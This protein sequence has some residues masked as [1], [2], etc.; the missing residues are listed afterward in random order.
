MLLSELVRVM[1]ARTA[2]TVRGGTPAEFVRV[3][4]ITEDSRTVVPGSLFIA[5]GG[6][7]TDGRKFVADAITGG[8]VAVM[9]DDPALTIDDPRIPLVVC[10]DIMLATAVG[11]EAF[12]GNPSRALALFGVTGTNG[13]ST[14]TYLAWK[15][16]NAHDRRCGLIG[17]VLIDDG[18]EVARAIMTTP[19]SIE[20]SRTFASMVEC[21]CVAAS[22]EVSSHALDQQ[23]CAAFA[24]RVGAF[25]NLTGDHLDYHK[26]MDNY[27]AAKAR[28]F[29]MLPTE[30]LAV[31]N[32]NDPAAERMV[33]DCKAPV[34]RCRLGAGPVDE[35]NATVEILSRSMRGMGLRLRGPWGDLESHVD[36]IG[37]YNAMNTLQAVAGCFALGLTGAD[38]HAALPSLDAPPGRLQRVSDDDSDV[39]VFVDYAHTDDALANVLQAV[40]RVI[41][42]RTH[43]SAAVK[44]AAGAD[45]SRE[46]I[47]RLWVVFG[48]GGDKDRTKR[49]RMGK[50]AAELADV[51]VVTSD[52]PR[53]ER[54]GQIIDEVLGGIP[55]ALRSKFTVQADRG[56]AIAH[57][58]REAGPRDVVVLA[59]KGHENTQILSDGKGG[60]VTINFDDAEVARRCLAERDGGS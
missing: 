15:L 19:P 48:C 35:H 54:P 36:L 51:V 7:K 13:K 17:T 4:D 3:C 12:Y 16:L 11:A 47:G 53:S 22:M 57:A 45:R 9:T 56:R 24:F 39:T 29:E 30:G 6:L 34:L 58:I 26:T 50:A 59:G 14:T 25:T 42:G 40:G 1:A 33:R 32:A 44:D 49:P 41:P 28:L 21:G 5:R 20:L 46:E 60:L 27:G 55:P 2:A 43:A 23:R 37:D 10:P 8:A 52:N 18:R 31:V 38:L